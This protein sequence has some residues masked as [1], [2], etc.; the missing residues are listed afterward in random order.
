MAQ[1]QPKV[2]SQQNITKHNIVKIYN[3]SEVQFGD[4]LNYVKAIA[5]GDVDREVVAKCPEQTAAL[6]IRDSLYVGKKT[7]ATTTT[8][9]S[10]STRKKRT[11]QDGPSSSNNNTSFAPP[12]LA[13]TTRPCSPS[14][15]QME[16][17]KRTKGAAAAP[18][19]RDMDETLSAVAE[20]MYTEDK[21]SLVMDE[22]LLPPLHVNSLGSVLLPIRRKSVL[23]RWTLHEISVFESAISLHGKRFDLISP[24]LNKSTGEVI[25]FYYSW[26]NSARAKAWKDTYKRDYEEDGYG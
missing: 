15:F 20:L 6:L 3:M 19:Q 10:S 12:T 23:E 26:K 17:R 2:V 8:T 9:S 5:R 14:L 13:S 16:P 18:P 22:K 11:V 25:E 21:S 4:V 24:L 1:K 7:P